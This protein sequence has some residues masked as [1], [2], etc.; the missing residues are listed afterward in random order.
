MKAI[1][2]AGGYGTRLQED[3]K[4]LKEIDSKEY[5]KYKEFLDVPKPL[6]KIAGEP[7]FSRIIKKVEK[8]T[9]S[10]VFVRVNND[11]INEFRKWKER[12]GGKLNIKLISDGSPDNTY[13]QGVFGG[14]LYILEKEKVND[15][16]LILAGDTIFDYDLGS[17][18]ESYQKRKKTTIV[19]HKERPEFIRLRGVAEFN[20]EQKILSYEEKP[21]NPKSIYAATPTFIFDKECSELIKQYIKETKNDGNMGNIVPWFLMKGK[22]A[23]AY[24]TDREIFDVGN[25][26]SIKL[27]QEFLKKKEDRAVHH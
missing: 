1:I 6:L 7:I 20:K 23:Y 27:A 26:E 2:L 10:D 15:D 5:E 3:I 8:T 4:K 22:E 14:V 21:Q 25:V 18:L 19:V 24:I 17:V 13:G 16:L 12:Y 11:N 9:I